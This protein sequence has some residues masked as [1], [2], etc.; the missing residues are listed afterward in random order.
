MPVI[1]ENISLGLPVAINRID[2]ELKKLWSESEG[3]MTR[4][5]M[6]D[7]AVYSEDPDSLTRNTQL[8]ARITENHACRGIVIAADPH[9]KN[10]RI[11]A[12]ISAHCHIGRAGTNKSARNRFHSSSKV[13]KRSSCPVS[14]FPSSIPIS[15]FI[16]GGNPNSPS[17]WIHSF[18]HGLIV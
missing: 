13:Q 9:S 12:W 15:H 1:A 18:G 11:E 4:A 6:M 17:R 2:R 5:S 16:S 8:L 3:A 7:L 10:D 14:F